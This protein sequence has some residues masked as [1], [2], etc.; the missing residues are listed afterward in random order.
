MK[1][2]FTANNP[3]ED[4]EQKLKKILSN[5]VKKEILL[6]GSVIE[7]IIEDGVHGT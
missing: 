2:R 1:S 6:D 4:Y 3:L 5:Y 7:T